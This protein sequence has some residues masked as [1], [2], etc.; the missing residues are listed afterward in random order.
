MF[1]IGELIPRIFFDFNA[2]AFLLL[3]AGFVLYYFRWRKGT[4]DI[5]DKQIV[6]NGLIGASI[7][8]EK[9]KEISFFHSKYFGHKRMIQ[10]IT[11]DSVFKVKFKNQDSFEDFSQK[12]VVAAGQFEG[13][14]IDT[15]F[16]TDYENDH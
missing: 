14:K 6:I 4:I 12:L 13:V 1:A 7:L 9:V 8:T 16:V 15:S 3:F 10:I 11:S 2:I 5:T